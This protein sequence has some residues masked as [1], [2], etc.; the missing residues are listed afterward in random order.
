MMAPLGSR[1]SVMF[2]LDNDGDLDI[3][4]NEF[5][6]APQLLVSNLA[7]RKPIHWLKI[8]LI[9]TSIKPEWAGRYCACASR[10]ARLYQ[11]Q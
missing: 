10:R 2:D 4:T 7:Q 5:N 1:S 11:I 6:S 3:V 8:V 9:G